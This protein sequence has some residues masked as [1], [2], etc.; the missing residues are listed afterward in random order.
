MT[1]REAIALKSRGERAGDTVSVWRY[2]GRSR[3]SGVRRT[4]VVSVNSGG[5]IADSDEASDA[6]RWR[7]Y[8][9]AEAAMWDE[10]GSY[11]AALEAAA[12]K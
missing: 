9:A 5:W 1:R 7:E 3:R 4:W 8:A 6:L 10:I 2:A 11:E 12:T